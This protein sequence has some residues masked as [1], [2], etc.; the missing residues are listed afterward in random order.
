MIVP[1]YNEAAT[2]EAVV[3]RLREVPLR[4]EIIVVDDAS[5]DQTGNILDRLTREGLLHHVIR[6]ETNRGKGAALRS[7]IVAATGDV[8]VAQDADLEYD[9]AELPALVQPIRQGRADAVLSR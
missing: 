3:R 9:P 2:L 5:T 8:I 7:G 1:A 4:V 6:H